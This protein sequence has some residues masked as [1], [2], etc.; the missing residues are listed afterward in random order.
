MIWIANIVGVC[1]VILF[2]LSYQMK[3]RK[4]IVATNA[5]S[6]ALYVA[7]YLLL[8]AYEGAVLEVVGI[9]ASVLAQHREKYKKAALWLCLGVNLLIVAVGLLLWNNWFSLLPM[10]GVLFH[11][12]AFWLTNE[13][14]IRLLSLLGSPCWLAY[15]LYCLAYGSALGDAFTICSILI[16]LLRFQERK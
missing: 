9:L 5:V 3:T 11:T 16:A 12:G 10:L 1:A 13:K 2:V 4:G 14:Y 7:Q 8:G 15:N 6:R